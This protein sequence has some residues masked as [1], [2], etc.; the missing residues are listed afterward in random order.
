MQSRNRN[1][2]AT[3]WVIFIFGVFQTT[4][5]SQNKGQLIK[6]KVS[7][8]VDPLPGVNITIKDADT[9][10]QTDAIGN[11]S[12]LAYPRDVLVFSYMGMKSVE[13]IVEDVTSVLN[14]ELMPII[15]ELDEVVV[16]KRRKKTREEL[17]L[18]YASNKRLVKSVFG[19]LDGER[20]GFSLRVIDASEINLVAGSIANVIQ[21]EFPGVRTRNWTNP[22]TGTSGPAIFLNRTASFG[23]AKPVIYDVDGV[24][25]EDAPPIPIENIK[26]IALI[27]GVSGTT[28]YGGIA[29]GGVVIINTNQGV[30]VREPGTDSPYDLAKLRNNFFEESN[31]KEYQRNALPKYLE[32]LLASN[33]FEEAKSIFENHRKVYGG[34]P[35]FYLDAFF[36]FSDAWQDKEISWEIN[37]HIRSSFENNAVILKTLAYMLEKAGRGDLALEVYLQVFRLRP[38]YGQSYRDLANAYSEMD[39]YKNA[40]KF[41][42]RYVESRKLRKTSAPSMG[43][44]SIVL[45]ELNQLL[46]KRSAELEEAHILFDE[47]T[48]YGTRLLFEWS[49]TEAEFKIQFVNPQK[50][51][52]IWNHTLEENY[53]RIKDEKIKGYSSEQFFMDENLVGNWQINLDYLGNKSFDPTYMKATVWTNY[54]TPFENKKLYFFRLSEQNVN[55][56]IF[57]VKNN[58]ML[59]SASKR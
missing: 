25:F 27:S 55:Q 34:S 53:D 10:T 36:Y 15:Q 46:K 45:T 59:E 13:I 29:S 38:A 28:R 50:Q 9:G 26:R 23:N 5:Y 57:S 11:Y 1:C 31:T 48:I 6:G 49:N 44:D 51:Y 43:I 24:I 12:I 41:Y 16:E 14:I 20:S 3:V 19:I 52:F 56:K 22:R 47:N 8:G 58:P 33:T 37:E 54:G 39:D 2:M 35:Y 40:L 7:D 4:I 30:Y 32:E 42:A 17:E 21:T 18:E